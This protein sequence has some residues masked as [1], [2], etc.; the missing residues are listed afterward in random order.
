MSGE[1]DDSL[2]I[3]RGTLSDSPV[4][5]EKADGLRRAI[6]RMT[7]LADERPGNYFVFHV[8]QRKVIAEWREDKLNVLEKE[9]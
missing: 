1:F 3:F 7:V 8:V 4:W 6:E 2:D 5:V 9:F